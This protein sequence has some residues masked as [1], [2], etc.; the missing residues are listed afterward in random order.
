[1]TIVPRFAAVRDGGGASMGV[2]DT[3]VAVDRFDNKTVNAGRKAAQA[4]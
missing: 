4:A 1:M 3:E 2:G